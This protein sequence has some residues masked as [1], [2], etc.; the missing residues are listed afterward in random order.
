[1]SERAGATVVEFA[2]SHSMHVSLPNAVAALIAK[3]AKGAKE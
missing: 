1:M 2:G 3:A